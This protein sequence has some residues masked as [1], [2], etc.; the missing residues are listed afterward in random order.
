MGGV[1]GIENQFVEPMLVEGN[2]GNKVDH[3]RFHLGSR[4]SHS[5]LILLLEEIEVAT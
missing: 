3:V 2:M 4:W 1:L 5:I